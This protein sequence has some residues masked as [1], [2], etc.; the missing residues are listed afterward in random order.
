MLFMFAPSLTPG[1]PILTINIILT[2][3]INNPDPDD[4]E[5]KVTPPDVIAMLWFDPKAGE[6]LG[7]R[8]IYTEEYLRARYG[9]TY[10]MPLIGK[11]RETSTP[12]ANIE[13]D[14]HYPG[15]DGFGAVTGTKFIKAATANEKGRALALDRE[16]SVLSIDTNGFDEMF[17][18]ADVTAQIKNLEHPVYDLLQR[19]MYMEMPSAMQH[20]TEAITCIRAIFWERDTGCAYP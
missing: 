14:G 12:F 7:K 1:R 15:R 8:K 9:S 2:K 16:T 11:T 19:H 17:N 5:M 20:Q 3:N 13:N 6:C 10:S 4:K 18:S